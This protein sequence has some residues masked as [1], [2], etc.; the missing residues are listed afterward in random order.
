MHETQEVIELRDYVF[1]E[2]SISEKAWD[3]SPQFVD[4]TYSKVAFPEEVPNADSYP[5][6][7]LPNGLTIKDNAQPC[8]ETYRVEDQTTGEPSQE[9]RREK[10][11]KCHSGKELIMRTYT[12]AKSLSNG[13][14]HN[15]SELI[16]GIF[17]VII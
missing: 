12:L 15:L 13:Q 9:V 11:S 3:R 7:C 8:T 4:D 1:E 5:R 14:H 17:G 2:N 6:V 10:P 16:V